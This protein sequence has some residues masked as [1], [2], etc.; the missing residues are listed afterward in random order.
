MITKEKLLEALS[1]VEEPDLKKDL[2]TLNMIKDIEIEGKNIS[3][4]VILTTP[5]CPLKELI[6]RACENAIIHYV[7]KDAK[8]TVNMTANVTSNRA[9]RELLPGVKNIIAVASGKGGVGKSTVSVNLAVALAQNGA[10]VGYL[11]ADIYG[12]SGPVM[13]GA[14][15]EKLFV[16][17]RNGQTFMLPIEK[18]GVKILSIGFMADPT[19]AI[20]WRGPMASKAL[21]QLFSDADW[22]ELDYLIVDLPPGT[23]DIHI[24]LVTAVPVTGAV[25]VSTPQKVALTDVRKGV[26]MFR[27]GAVNVPVLGLVE[28]MSFFTPPELPDKKYYLFGKDGVKQMAMQL[29]VPF[30]GEIPLEQPIREGG[31]EGKPAVL[32]ENS[33]AAHAFKALAENVAQ[34]VSI[35]N[36]TL[37]P[38]K[39]VE[40]AH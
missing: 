3:F 2:V 21:R 17:E 4:T 26:E 28:N 7:D 19:K 5:A 6:R 9:T 30:L 16:N 24:T 11:D 40:T 18:Y 1:Y 31:D 15:N 12:P 23:G 32:K 39:Q 27:M 38:T 33:V 22:G 34:Q 13:F 14:E 8:V 35:R 29:E 10:K 36:S 20:V 37:A 25:I